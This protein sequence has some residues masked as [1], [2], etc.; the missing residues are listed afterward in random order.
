MS[1]FDD[2]KEALTVS[3][4]CRGYGYDPNRAGFIRCPFHSEKT[5]SLKLYTRAFHCYGCGAHGSVIDFTA[6]LFNLEPLEAVK[7]LNADF[8][9]GLEVDRSP[10]PQEQNQ[11]RQ[12]REAQALFDGWREQM[13]DK[14]GAAIRV[15]N[16][17]DYEDLT[18][19][20]VTAILFR[21]AFEYWSDILLHAP[22]SAQMGVF[23]DREEVERLCKMILQDTPTKSKTA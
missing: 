16:L 13:L 14:M 3:Q 20:E 8:H 18:D 9:L 11:L 2:V 7:K 23:R 12:I 6:K 22:L 19:S 10:D 15:A 21:E 17:A 4:V 1:V 5:P